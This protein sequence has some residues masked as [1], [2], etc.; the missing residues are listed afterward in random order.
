MKILKEALDILFPQCCLICGKMSDVSINKVPV[1]KKCLADMVLIPKYQRWQFCLS[2]PYK[3]DRYPGL[4]LYICFVYKGKVTDLIHRVKFGQK[5]E[6]ARMMGYL[7]GNSLKADGVFV[8][9][10]IPIPLSY[11]RLMERGFNQAEEMGIEISRILN[12]PVLTGVISRPK[13]TKRQAELTD[14]SQRARNIS[15]A[16]SFNPN[17][18]VYG[19]TILLVD[20]VATTGNTLHEA[21]SVLLENGADNVLCCAFAGNRTVK[22][23]ETY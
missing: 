2:E 11:G 5:A 7:T 8:D 3:G 1:C 18:S 6:L 20:D 16:F 9:A 4:P 23:A 14:D 10:V 21:S 12:V 17:Y 13:E 19:M 22:N 15:G